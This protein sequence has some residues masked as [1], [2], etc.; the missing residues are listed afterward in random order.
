MKRPLPPIAK[1][2][3]P[4]EWTILGGL[5][6]LLAILS[7]APLQQQL[8]AKGVAISV[9]HARI[10]QLIDAAIWIVL[11]PVAFRALDRLPLRRTVWPWHLL[12][13][14]GLAFVFGAIHAA[15]AFP[16]LQLAA[17]ALGVSPR[18]LA[19]PEFRFSRM[20]LDDS[21][22]FGM[23]AIA[24][25]I[26]QVIHRA[27][28][29]RRRVGEVE[30]SLREARLHALGL[31]LQP[32]FL[33]NTLNGIAALVRSDPRTAEQ[34]LVRLSDLLRLT[35]GSGK[36]GHLP[37]GE[38]LRQLQLYLAL[39]KMRHGERLTVETEIP[40][41][42]QS[43]RVPAMLLQP[44]VENALTHGIGGRPGPGTLR[45]RAWREDA[46][47]YLSVEDDGVGV[48][49][50]GPS[51]EGIGLKNTRARLEAM[52]PEQ[53][54]FAVEPRAGGG[55]LVLIRFPYETNGSGAAP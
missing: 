50:G 48:P 22:N 1:A 36:L 28:A 42:L 7:A 23:V 40:G 49:A 9:E 55:T 15:I 35:L 37:L 27:R 17:D 5:W 31:E 19:L 24:Y 2:M 39:Q 25:L 46:R 6:L 13:W 53:H 45:L 14:F 3:R 4:L 12:G 33:F 18:V 52:Y 11:L 20:A 10:G 43:A 34:M 38:E 21:N 26:L 30:R 51:R 41:E 29:E 54:Q 47:L 16:V 8:A 32:H 44:L